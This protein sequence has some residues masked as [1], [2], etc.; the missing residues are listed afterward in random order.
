MITVP[1]VLRVAAAERLARR[2]RTQIPSDAIQV[3][4]GAAGYVPARIEVERGK[5]VRLAFVRPDGNN[6]GG[7]VLFPGRNL[8][9]ALP[10]GQVVLVELTPTEPGEIGFTCGM[11]MLEGTLVVK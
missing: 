2:Q 3:T 1:F 10:V 9:Y 4:V 5:P 8:K 7:T 11:G 6:C